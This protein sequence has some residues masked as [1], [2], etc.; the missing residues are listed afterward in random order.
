MAER[1][2]QPLR[3]DT[4]AALLDYL[5]ATSQ[6]EW[7]TAGRFDTLY[8]TGWAPHQSQQQPLKPQRQGAPGEALGTA[9][10]S[11]KET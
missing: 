2:R 1:S 4:L 9:E 5:C 11:L 7:K 6:R 8:L 3:R 10:A